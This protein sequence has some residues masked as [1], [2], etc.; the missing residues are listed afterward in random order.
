MKLKCIKDITYHW[1]QQLIVGEY[2]SILSYEVSD[3]TIITNFEK[4]MGTNREVANSRY[5]LRREDVDTKAIGENNRRLINFCKENYTK[6]LSIPTIIMG[7]E[8]NAKHAFINLSKEEMFQ[9]GCDVGKDGYPCVETSYY[10]LDEYFETISF[11]RE[12]RLKE[13]GIS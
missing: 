10:L 6:C 4:W 5:D 9:L 12:L 13:L 1:G 2:Y 7:G 3:R 8:N 11:R